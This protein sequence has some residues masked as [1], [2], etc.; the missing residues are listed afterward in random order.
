MFGL[1][2]FLCLGRIRRWNTPSVV[3]FNHTCTCHGNIK[4]GDNYDIWHFYKA[5][6]SNSVY[7]KYSFNS[8][9]NGNPRAVL[10]KFVLIK[11]IIYHRMIENKKWIILWFQKVFFP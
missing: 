2:L 9:C 7:M 10:I 8:A 11:F 1:L 3:D 5:K 4:N 6:S